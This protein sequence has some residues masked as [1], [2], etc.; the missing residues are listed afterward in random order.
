MS[1]IT[2]ILERIH[3]AKS[4]LNEHQEIVRVC[5]ECNSVRVSICISWPEADARR[6]EMRLQT[7]ELRPA[8]GLTKALI[9]V[10]VKGYEHQIGELNKELDDAIADLVELRSAR[11]EQP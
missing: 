7:R 6:Q 5:T 8:K 9:G 3:D 2:E 10:L 4:R 11:K 1:E